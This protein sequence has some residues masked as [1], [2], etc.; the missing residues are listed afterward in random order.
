MS[1]IQAA[2]IEEVRARFWDDLIENSTSGL[3]VIEMPDDLETLNTVREILKE[4]D[5][6]VFGKLNRQEGETIALRFKGPVGT[7]LEREFFVERLQEIFNKAGL[8]DVA[9]QPIRNGSSLLDEECDLFDW[10]SP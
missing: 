6:E 1:G 5:L 3:Y 10:A 8:E 2:Q 4:Q 7:K 9:M